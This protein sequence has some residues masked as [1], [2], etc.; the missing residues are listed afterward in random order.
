MKITD[1]KWR[2][3]ANEYDL[4]EKY[5]DAT[6]VVKTDISLRLAT[7]KEISWEHNEYRLITHNEQAIAFAFIGGYNEF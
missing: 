5:P 6:I 2:D 7:P 4:L 1:T 3:V